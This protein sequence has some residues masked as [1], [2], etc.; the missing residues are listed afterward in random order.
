MAG[1]NFRFRLGDV[2]GRA[3]TILSESNFGK[4]ID[5]AAPGGARKF[6]V[7]NADQGGTP[8][9]PFVKEGPWET[10]SITS[11][12]PAGSTLAIDPLTGVLLWDKPTTSG[13]PFSVT[14]TASDAV[15]SA[16]ITYSLNVNSASSVDAPAAK[17]KRIP[18]SRFS[19]VMFRPKGSTAKES[20]TGTTRT[21]GARKWTV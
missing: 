11:N 20:N 6:N 3:V 10:F 2:E 9:F 13:A 16:S 21:M 18:A 1:D 19:G 14:V 5:I 4:D 8:G 17:K 7:P 12:V 15:S